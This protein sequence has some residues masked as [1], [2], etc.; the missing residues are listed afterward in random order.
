VKKKLLSLILLLLPV[1]ALADTLGT[2]NNNASVELSTQA[3]QIQSSLQTGATVFITSGTVASYLADQALTNGGCV[4]AGPNGQ[5]TTPTSNACGTGSGGGAAS[6]TTAYG[7]LYTSSSS[8]TQTLIS[9][10]PVVLNAFQNT[11]ASYQTVLSTTAS[12]IIVSTGGVFYVWA[13]ILSTGTGTYNQ[14]FSIGINGSPTAY[15]CQDTPSARCVL[16]SIVS[17][18][19]GSTVQIYTNTS[20]VGQATCTITDAQFGLTTITGPTGPQGLSNFISAGYAIS[21]VANGSTT[22]V[23]LLGNSTNYIQNSSSLQSNTTFYVSSAAVK[24]PFMVIGSTNATPTTIEGP[25]GSSTT[26]GPNNYSFILGNY[27]SHAAGTD[28][29][30]GLYQYS[31]FGG[32]TW[33]PFG[34]IECIKQS[35]NY[36]NDGSDLVFRV[37]SG[38]AG[39]TEAL[40]L[41]GSTTNGVGPTVKL[42]GAL[43]TNGSSGTFG[44]VLQSNGA[45]VAPSWVVNSPGSNNF[46]LLQSTLQAGATFYVSSAAVAGNLTIGTLTGNTW[47]G[48][49]GT[50]TPT[51]SMLAE[52]VTMSDGGATFL[53]SQVGSGNVTTLAS[54]GGG[55]V[56]TLNENSPSTFNGS[57]SLG[58]YMVNQPFGWSDS[59]AKVSYIQNPTGYISTYTLTLPIQLGTPGQVL[60]QINSTGTLSFVS[61]AGAGVSFATGTILQTPSAPAGGTWLACDGSVQSTAT[62]PALYNAIGQTYMNFTSTFP[63]STNTVSAASIP[64]WLGNSNWL[65]TSA[66]GTAVWWGSTGTWLT[67]TSVGSGLSAL[68]VNLAVGYALG[69]T[70]TTAA[71]LTASLTS[72]N[73]VGN[74]LPSAPGSFQKVIAPGNANTA[75]FLY[76]VTGSQTVYTM[77]KGGTTWASTASA[78]PKTGTPG[79]IWWDGTDW[80]ILMTNG[81]LEQTSLVSGTANWTVAYSSTSIL[82]LYAPIMN[83]QQNAE[84]GSF[85]NAPNVVLAPFSSGNSIVSSNSLLT[86]TQY[87]QSFVTYQSP[88]S[89]FWNGYVYVAIVAFNSSTAVN[90]VVPQYINST[91]YTS[92]DGKVWRNATTGIFMC[93]AAQFTG[94]TTNTLTAN[95]TTGA[96]LMLGENAGGPSPGGTNLMIVF[97]TV[98]PASQFNLPLQPGYYI[99]AL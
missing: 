78:L 87:P 30:L 31:S 10:T 77:T 83:N 50:L 61:S 23:S 90:N 82:A 95:T 41:S 26:A 49:L 16:T 36:L 22:T 88:T 46:I 86:S 55:T 57:S 67:Q 18:S 69:Y 40:R 85:D 80:N 11:G 53:Q 97:P 20:L 17:L 12:S 73:F 44:Y 91:I 48:T 70:N 8:V 43:Y 21:A 34:S 74:T 42:G 3:V 59:N 6:T 63:A 28:V 5:F 56:L 93:P 79:A 29:S 19:A 72:I 32:G 94:T 47:N 15:T 66:N 14:Y 35:D 54:A 75:V 1:T 68:S 76:C 99:R 60:E 71:A 24:G 7:L 45:N 81:V 96:F 4:Q 2:L 62:Y 39:S 58:L 13:N 52:G 98:N 37:Y 92:I 25:F 89:V 51:I 9:T 38:G 27:G 64:V 84:V 33:T 65:V